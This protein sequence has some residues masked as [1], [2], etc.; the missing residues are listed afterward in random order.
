VA[1]S[2]KCKSKTPKGKMTMLAN[3]FTDRPE[4]LSLQ[5]GDSS[6]ASIPQNDKNGVG[7]MLSGA[8]M[9]IRCSVLARTIWAAL[10]NLSRAR[11]SS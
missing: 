4:G 2:D 10:T 1:V 11:V 8:V 5:G 3:N 7:Y 9:P 6:V